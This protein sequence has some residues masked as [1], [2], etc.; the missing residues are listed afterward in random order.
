MLSLRVFTAGNHLWTPLLAG[1]IAMHATAALSH[2]RHGKGAGQPTSQSTP[3]SKNNR[4]EHAPANTGQQVQNRDNAKPSES[5]M[6]DR[7]PADGKSLEVKSRDFKG[8]DVRTLVNH[9]APVNSETDRRDS[10]NTNPIDTRITVQSPLFS[11][12]LDRREPPK[13]PAK[14]GIGIK[15]K[16][17]LV[18]R[19]HEPSASQH[20]VRNAVGI[21]VIVPDHPDRGR[22]PLTAGQHPNSIGPLTTG[23]AERSAA[24][25]KSEKLTEPEIVRPGVATGKPFGPA[26]LNRSAVDGT[27]VVRP[28]FATS[29]I[30]GTPRSPTGRHDLARRRRR[31]YQCRAPRCWARSA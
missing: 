7:E 25:E 8:Q 1:V 27:M 19:D 16:A 13:T 29:A 17:T 9:T 10:R 2:I 14:V 26:V 18:H 4:V 22:E 30:S 11:P 12:R 6:P 31:V 24:L 23:Q 3:Q 15:L 20:E 5:G 28:R 21:A